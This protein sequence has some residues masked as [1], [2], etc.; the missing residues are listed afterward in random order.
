MARLFADEDDYLTAMYEL[1]RD[2]AEESEDDLDCWNPLDEI[3]P[4]TFSGEVARLAV[5]IKKVLDTPIAERGPV[6]KL[7]I[8]TEG[9]KH[10]ISH[11]GRKERGQPAI[12][13]FLSARG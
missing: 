5:D 7:K 2:T 11:K 1:A 8:K 6:E 3:D 4:E 9:E 12:R 13:L 10:C